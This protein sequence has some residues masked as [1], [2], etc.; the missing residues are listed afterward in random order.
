MAEQC[1]RIERQID[2]TKASLVDK[3][4]A[5]ESQFAEVIQTT[6]DSVTETMDVVKDTVHSVREKIRSAGEFLDLKQRV[7]RNPWTTFGC[8]I[9]SGC[10]AGYLLGGNGRRTSS[11]TMPDANHEAATA[12]GTHPESEQPMQKHSWLR[13]QLESVAGLATAA[14]MG[15]LRDLAARNLPEG[16]GKSVSQEVDRFT[17]RLG[18]QPISGPVAPEPKQPAV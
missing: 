2:E 1:E 10:F 5:L 7:E 14:L 15:T 9:A 11:A 4:E 12:A 16:L 3:L 6:A 8:S 18:A 17:E 13:E